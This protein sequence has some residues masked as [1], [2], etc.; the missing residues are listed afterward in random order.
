M[1]T[2]LN[3][4]LIPLKLFHILKGDYDI[5]T[6]LTG[7]SLLSFIANTKEACCVVGFEQVDSFDEKKEVTHPKKHENTHIS[8]KSHLKFNVFNVH[9]S[10]SE[11]K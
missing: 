7:W 1:G 3:S 4:Y 11:T 2:L 10:E 5:R 9:K 6:L 8:I